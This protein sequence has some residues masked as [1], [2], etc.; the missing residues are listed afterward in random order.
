MSSGRVFQSLGP[1]TANDQ[2]PTVTSCDRGMTSSEEVDDQR[3]RLDVMSETRRRRSDRFRGAVPWTAWLVDNDCQIK[4]DVLRCSQPVKTGK[5]ICY[6]LITITLTYSTQQIQVEYQLWRTQKIF[7][8]TTSTQQ[9]IIST[10]SLECTKTDW[11]SILLWLY[12]SS[13]H[14]MKA[15]IIHMVK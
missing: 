7:H 11:Q 13:L 9:I 6:M 12:Y 14:Q 15:E 2:S 3:R 1:A 8:N 10:T 5:L 4:H